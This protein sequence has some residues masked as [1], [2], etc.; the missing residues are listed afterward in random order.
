M[1]CPFQRQDAERLGLVLESSSTNP[2]KVSSLG[3]VPQPFV[4]GSPLLRRNHYQELWFNRAFLMWLLPK[5]STTLC[6]EVLKY[7]TL[8]LTPVIFAYLSSRPP[9]R[10]SDQ[11]VEKVPGKPC[12][13]HLRF[14]VNSRSDNY[15][16]PIINS[17]I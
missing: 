6:I 1:G 5:Y 11:Y 12:T 15:V 7:S 2:A 8:I 10:N 14:W 13:N 16:P 17:L 4:M 3:F 9:Q